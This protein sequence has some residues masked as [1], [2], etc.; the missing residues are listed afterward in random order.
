MNCLPY[1]PTGNWTHNL[2]M[3]PDQNWIR[4]LFWYMGQWSN[5][6][7]HLARTISVQIKNFSYILNVLQRHPTCPDGWKRWGAVP[8]SRNQQLHQPG[9]CCLCFTGSDLGVSGAPP[10]KTLH[11]HTTAIST[12]G[13][14]ASST[15]TSQ[16][17][18]SGLLFSGR[19]IR[20]AKT[21]SPCPPHSHH[22]AG[23]E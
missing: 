3:C 11:Q 8:W 2:G 6:L 1:A 4:G 15:D 13:K 9:G 17:L 14:T 7:S 20:G 10:T 21:R 16:I 22:R 19:S 5:Q 12:A 18:M 23:W